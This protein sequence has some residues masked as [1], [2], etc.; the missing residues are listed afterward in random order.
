MLILSLPDDEIDNG[1]ANAF[2]DT[3]P[4]TVIAKF[5]ADPVKGW[6]FR[7]FAVKGKIL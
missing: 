7:E 5:E 1:E 6:M 3:T 2:M 4:P